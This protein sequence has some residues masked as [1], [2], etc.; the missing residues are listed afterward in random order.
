MLA[1]DMR[2]AL[3]G[4]LALGVLALGDSRLT[5]PALAG[6]EEPAKATKVTI[7]LRGAINDKSVEALRA[8]LKK[9]TGIKF[10]PDAIQKGEEPAFFTNA[11][12]IEITDH[13]KTD[14]GAVAKVA[15]EAE[16]PLKAELKPGLHLWLYPTDQVDERLI[17]KVRDALARTEGVVQERGIGGSPP[18]Q[19]IWIRLDGSGKAKLKTIL[20]TLSDAGVHVRLGSASDH[21]AGRT[22][23]IAPG[24]IPGGSRELPRRCALE[25]NPAALAVRLLS[26][27]RGS[28]SWQLT[29]RGS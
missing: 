18:D 16:T 19:A 10:N 27:A 5:M 26:P 29:S 11:F 1:I 17:V 6:Q 15:A 2:A 13:D 28:Q 20:E 14:L 3:H 7:Q 22:I 21:Q 9:V 8:A 4:L 24:C 25:D 23:P 12:T